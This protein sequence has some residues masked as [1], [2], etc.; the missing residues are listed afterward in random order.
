VHLCSQKNSQ[1]CRAQSKTEITSNGRI[2]LWSYPQEQRIANPW[3]SVHASSVALTVHTRQGL[4]S[5]SQWRGLKG[6]LCVLFISYQARFR[7][8]C[9]GCSVSCF[10]AAPFR[11]WSGEYEY[12]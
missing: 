2:K 10:S 11:P 1:R 4:C 9:E 8:N 6:L 5:L 12:R 7:C 3:P